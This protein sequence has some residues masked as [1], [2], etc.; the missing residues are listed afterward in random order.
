MKADLFA[1][2]QFDKIR[3]LLVE[4]A[5]T[6]PG[7][8][9]LSHLLPYF[10]FPEVQHEIAKVQ[11]L[12]RLLNERGRLPLPE[13]SSLTPLLNT[14]K[15]KYLRVSE[16][17]LTRRYI[18]TAR[19]LKAHLRGLPL[20][21]VK[22]LL[23]TLPDFKPLLLRL[24][25]VLE[26]DGSGVRDE[27]SARLLTLR[28]RLFGAER[29]LK[30]RL[31][32]VLQKAAR[33]GILQEEIITQRRGRYVLPVKAEARGRLPGILHDTSASGATVYIEPAEV[34]PLA[35]ELEA[36]RL[37]EE[38][39]VARILTVLTEEVLAFA[40]GLKQLEEVIAELDS[41]EARA[42]FGEKISGALPEVS[43][44][45][46]I[47]LLSAA[48]PLL[49]LSGRK[50]VRNDFYFPNDK[51]IVVISGPNL[52][53]KT[54][55]LKTVGLLCLMVQ[56]GIPIPASP[57]S[58]LPVFEEILADIGDEQDLSQ[59]E[60]TF[61]AHVRRLKEIV[62]R[63][64]EGKLFLIDEIG[65]GTDPAEGAALGMAVLEH[66][67]GT[68]ARV[69]AT[70]HY[71]ALKAFSFSRK[72][73]LPL[74]VSFDEET[75]EPTYRLTYGVSGLSRGLSLARRL[76]LPEEIIRRAE[77]FLGQGDEAF[78]EVL[79]TLRR[80]LEDLEETQRAL[81]A[82]E[83][84]LEEERARLS[85]EAEALRKKVSEEEA[86][87]R[88]EYQQRLRALDEEF[89]RVVGEVKASR[90]G[91]RRAQEEF[92]RFLQEK[93][94]EVLPCESSSGPVVPGARVKLKGIGQEGRI[95]RVKGKLVEV[96]LGPFKVEVE[97]KDLVVLPDE[98]RP[99]EGR[100]F[101]VSTTREVPATINLI[102]LR[103]EEALSVLDKFIDQAFLSGKPRL[104]VIHGL[105]T[106][107]LMR[108][109]RKHLSTHAQVA[110]VRAGKAFEGGEAV[111]V[112][113][114][115]TGEGGK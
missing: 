18:L 23:S 95:L 102:G 101:S 98:G 83:K 97:E 4:E 96:Q 113:E 78:R 71:E 68:G 106:G 57:D 28:K 45:G 8:E 64:R 73:I 89:R 60:S 9:R 32:Q 31:R 87:L 81:A 11:E 59:D 15:G 88:E 65:R 104:T 82:K 80:S 56:A 114:L 84:A 62:S 3:V 6:Q 69:L 13:L 66:L 54:V 30:E 58:R 79:E 44:S 99:K 115:A 86:R 50:V 40:E 1:K 24:E 76:G 21:R 112:V 70:T 48:H 103:V 2:L 61:S 51:P 29:A 67:I 38:R 7:K 55:S 110:R 85:L 52:G 27:A 100:Y 46:E 5:K 108:A 12:A 90:K 17:A 75:G 91:V 72:E 93:A 39:E 34:I 42:V 49:L 25:E 53:G 36:L 94:K 10:T 35:N 109:V 107:R 77:D 74:S 22:G 43:P 20:P 47:R 37:E 26:P 105:G 19:E 41:L 14:P 111:T 63:A 33:A 16:L 92:A